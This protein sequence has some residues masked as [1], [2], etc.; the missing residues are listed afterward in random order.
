MRL[1]STVYGACSISAGLL[2]TACVSDRVAGP[3]ASIPPLFFGINAWMPKQIGTEV[4]N[5]DLEQYLCGVSYVNPGDACIPAEI[6]ASGVEIMRYGGSAIEH[7][8][9][10]TESLAQYAEMVDNMRDNGI[11]PVLQVPYG[12]G[13]IDDGTI[14][15]RP[16]AEVAAEL[17]TYINVTNNKDVKYWSIGNEPDK[18]QPT[19]FTAQEIRTY[20]KEISQAMKDVDPWIIITGPDLSFYSAPSN[21]AIMNSLTDCGFDDLTGDP[22]FGPDDITGSLISAKDGSTRYYV[23][24]LNFHTYPFDPGPDANSIAYDRADVIAQP[25]AGFE[26]TISNR[27][28]ERVE[29]CND[30]H[31]RTGRRALKM[32]VTE[33]NVTYRNPTVT[34]LAGVDEYASVGAT[35]FLAGQYWAEV[36]SI[37]IKNG[38]EGITFWSVKEGDN[39]GYIKSDSAGGPPPGGQDGRKLSTYYHFQMMAKHFRGTY[40]A[41]TDYDTNS[42]DIPE[43]KAFGSKAANQ[44]VVMILNQSQSTDYA[45]TVGF[46]SGVIPSGSNPLKIAMDAAVPMVEYNSP[47]DLTKESTVLL[48]FDGSGNIRRRHVYSLADAQSGGAPQSIR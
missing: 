6:K 40:A 29:L 15:G 27:L 36:M 22:E 44:I 37:G 46:M 42:V 19:A 14:D 8:Y 9:D 31:G 38:L 3:A 45:Y 41:G 48:V 34:Q 18:H 16:A 13:T 24:I 25:V 2:C 4:W 1:L 47:Q 5:G 20:F 30:A 28:K 11:E 10:V 12:D 39:L 23:D 43:V 32:A 35:S 21:D 7:D 17:V 33:M 26:D